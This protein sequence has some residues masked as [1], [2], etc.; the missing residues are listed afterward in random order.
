[1]CQ[2]EHALSKW[3][4]LVYRAQLSKWKAIVAL[5]KLSKWKVV[6]CAAICQLSIWKL[7]YCAAIHFPKSECLPCH[8]LS[9][10]KAA[11]ANFQ[12]RSAN[13]SNF[14]NGKLAIKQQ[15]S[16][17]KVVCCTRVQPVSLENVQEEH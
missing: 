15:H 16:K 3:K 13:F 1:M 4:V 9:K 10:W 14:P 2:I 11:S 8:Q 7:F 12:K 17:C 6:L 5:A